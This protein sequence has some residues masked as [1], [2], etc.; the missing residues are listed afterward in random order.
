MLIIT[1]LA[2]TIKQLLIIFD[3]YQNEH[4]GTITIN[5]V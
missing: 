5:A 4:H 1:I 3:V 2:F